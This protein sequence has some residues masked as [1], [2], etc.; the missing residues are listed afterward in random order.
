VPFLEVEGLIDTKLSFR[1]TS[2]YIASQELQK[3]VNVAI[4]LGRP[5]LIKGE[6]GSGLLNLVWA[7]L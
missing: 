2:D 1:G 5:L 6:P 3:S 7:R 4:T